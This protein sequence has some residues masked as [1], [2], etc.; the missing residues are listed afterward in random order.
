MSG[1]VQAVAAVL[2]GLFLFAPPAD[3]QKQGGTLRVTHRDNPPSASIHEEA[4][5]ST[6]MPFMSVYNNLV[7]FDQSK[8]QNS[9]DGIVPELATSWKWNEDGTKLTFALR[10]G[11]KWH[12]GK[13]FTAADVKCTWDQIIGSTEARFRKNPRKVWYQ[14]LKEVTVNGDREVTFH[15]VR[16]QPSLL[17]MLA[18]GFSPIYPCHVPAAQMRTKPIGTGPFKFVE[19]KQNESMKVV[20]NPDYWKPGRPYLDAIEFTIIANRSTSILSFVAGKFDMTF[21]ADITVPLLKDVRSQAP[22]AVCEMLPTNTQANLLINRDKPP[23][24]DAKVRRAMILSI[25]RKAFV[26]ILAEGEADIGGA[27]LPPPQ[28]LWGMT[29]EYLATVPGY[30]PDVEKS[31]EEA[32]KIM[33]ELG[34]G[35][36]KPLKIKVST[37]NIPAYRDPS[38]ILIDHLKHVHI[39]GELEPLD[40]P[41]WYARMARKDYSVGMNVQGV[42]IDDPDVVFYETYSCGSERNYTNYCNPELEKLFAQ[43]STITDQTKRRALVW[44]IDKRLQEDGARPVILHGRGATCWQPSVKGINMAVNSIY[45][46]WRFE[47]VWLD[48]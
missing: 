31:R 36:E 26:D 1:R 17:A 2:A 41:V 25:D 24:D 34:Y 19:F 4:T 11:V 14:N 43:Q 27:I 40:T 32:R 9:L 16:P 7:L 13:P 45:N 30:G 22:Q 38:V 3:A 21:T 10:D 44:E 47:D 29:K 46:H 33:R 18:G 15:V 35:P 5:I 8:K 39:D 23:F 28:G 12:D 48:R 20:R 6:V 37:R 42:G